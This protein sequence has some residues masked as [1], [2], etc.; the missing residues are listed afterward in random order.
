MPNQITF[1]TA[2]KAFKRR[3]YRNRK[4]LNIANL[5]YTSVAKTIKYQLHRGSNH[6]LSVTSIKIE[7]ERGTCHIKLF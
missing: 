6:L 2:S 7:K 3:Q 4:F 1:K 5:V